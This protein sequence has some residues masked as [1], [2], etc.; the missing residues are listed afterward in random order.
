MDTGHLPFTHGFFSNKSV[1]VSSS[2]FDE[3]TTS[4]LFS[5]AVISASSLVVVFIVS[6]S[7]L[8]GVVVSNSVEP[9]FRLFDVGI[10]SSR[11]G[12]N[13]TATKCVHNAN[14]TLQN[15]ECFFFQFFFH[16]ICS[17]FVNNRFDLLMW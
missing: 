11:S 5:S 9:V 17:F 10:R 14:S 16:F 7:S 8:A 15:I 13:C 12:C 4:V 2:S 6:S 1:V 3:L